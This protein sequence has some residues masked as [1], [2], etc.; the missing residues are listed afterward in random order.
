[1]ILSRRV[2]LNGVQVD[3]LDE[4]I[5]IQEFDPGTPAENI[6]TVEKMGGVGSRMTSRH[7]GP[8]DA[9]L[10]LAID[11]PRR[12]MVR[13]GQVYELIKRWAR[14]GG[15]LTF[16]AMNN[17][18]MHVDQVILPSRG[19]LRAF[20]DE[21]TI[22]FRNHFVPFWQSVTPATASAQ[23]STGSFGIT[24]PGDLETVLDAELTNISGGQIEELTIGIDGRQLVFTAMTLGAGE[25]LV[26]SHGT[27]GLLRTTVNGTSV[28]GKLTGSDDLVCG[29][30]SKT[31][32]VVCEGS[33]EA[34]VSCRGR[35][36]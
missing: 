23:V 36:L 8:L 6:G 4:S 30:G 14:M 11:V 33:L 17:V 2:A 7:W 26:I 3:E 22:T 19:D 31:V 1:M 29:P 27:D 34:A 20:E 21:Y 10:V 15:W 13:R 16:N 9:K 32:S 12:D 24:V 18:Q 28:Y 25:T 35:F 5:V